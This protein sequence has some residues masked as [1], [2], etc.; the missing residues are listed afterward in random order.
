M[1]NSAKIQ[2]IAIRLLLSMSMLGLSHLA[3]AEAGDF[4]AYEIRV[5][6][7]RY[8][9]KRNRLELGGQ[10]GLIMNQSFI[11]TVLMTGLLDFHFSEMF[12]IEVGLA[13][14]VSFDKEDKRI[15]SDEFEITT[16]LLP[17]D[18]ALSGGLLWTP[19]YGKTQLPSGYVVY[20]DNFISVQGG[21]TGIA[22][23]YKKCKDKNNPNPPTPTT[24]SYPTVNLGFGQKFF[25][26]Q[27]LSLRWDA[28]SNVFFYD[29]ADGECFPV[30][31]S[32]SFQNNLSVQI[33]ASTFF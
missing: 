28:R 30:A 9:T 13:K 14:G 6:R 7:P 19:M 26:S 20:F 2:N 18:Y 5:I 17:T 4:S 22:Y 31:S 16:A 33:G 15:L 3:M 29:K 1:I 12:A 32:S 8:M 11:Y 27:N 23:D 10:T 25:V 21:M 24:K